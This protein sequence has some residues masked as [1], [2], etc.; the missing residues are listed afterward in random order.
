MAATRR[1]RPRDLIGELRRS[2]QQFRL[3][4]AVRLLALA[5]PQGRLRHPPLPTSLRFRTQASLAFPASE[6]TAI[7][8]R[9]GHTADLAASTDSDGMPPAAGQHGE[10]RL[11]VA[12]LGL[13]GPLGVLPTAYTELLIERRV[14][15]RDESAHAFLDLFSH[16]ALALFYGAWRKYRFH[17]AHELGEDDSFRAGLRAL[18]GMGGGP[19]DVTPGPAADEAAPPESRLPANGL[20]YY[21]GLLARRPVSATAIV[22]LVRGLFGVPA[23]LQQFVG[24][25]VAIPPA[26]QTCLGSSG[27]VLG[28][29]AGVGERAWDSQTKCR[30]RL[31][32][33]PA[34][35]YRDFLPDQPGA[36]ALADLLRLC[37]GHG[38]G[39]DLQLIL[40]C[41]DVP[42]PQLVSGHDVDLP[43]LGHTLWLASQPPAIDPDHAVFSLLA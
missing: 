39:L 4:Q 36:L 2:P 33:L 7:D 9:Y 16:R 35:R 12:C 24:Q 14:R 38:L 22:T 21:A 32:P 30:L 11:E 41:R 18:T 37:V 29:S 20:L 3:F 25:W 6:I 26:E 19:P 13:T 23:E 28:E 1:D 8:E 17:L 43:R 5:E 42:P 31:G 27:A 40:A 15:F 34:E 10:W